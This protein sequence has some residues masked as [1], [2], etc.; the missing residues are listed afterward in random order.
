MNML[1][2]TTESIGCEIKEY[3]GIV[4]AH[5]VLG[6]NMFSDFSASISDSFGGESDTYSRK[7]SK[8]NDVVLNRI[9]RKA[10]IMGADAVV[11]VRLDFSEISGKGKGMLMASAFGTAI[12]VERSAN[13]KD[14]DFGIQIPRDVVINEIKSNELLEKLELGLDA[15]TED[16][17]RII[18]DNNSDRFTHRLYESIINNLKSSAL[19][20]EVVNQIKRYMD[21]TSEKDSFTKLL[22]NEFERKRI[23]ESLI[24]S[25]IA[26]FDAMFPR[27]FFIQINNIENTKK[28]LEII[29]KNDKEYYEEVDKIAL[30]QILNHVDKNK[31]PGEIKMSKNI[32][33]KES[34]HYVCPNGHKLKDENAFCDDLSCKQNRFGFTAKDLEM[35]KVI[36]TKIEILERAFS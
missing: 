15:I 20:T 27:L 30:E 10:A 34:Q 32:F 24:F 11:G 6:T 5:C 9:K 36:K 2:T 33:G 17:W 12:R 35:I 19:S 22:Y 18:I 7:L 13:K 28:M 8:I 25:M 21:E 16:E 3:L 14:V 1:V 23:S 31:D 26:T 29:A 4:S